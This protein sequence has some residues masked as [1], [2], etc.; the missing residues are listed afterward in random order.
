[1]LLNQGS[2]GGPRILCPASIATVTRHQVVN[3]ISWINPFIN[4]ASVE[5]ADTDVAGRAHH[6]EDSGARE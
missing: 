4:A 6:S 2:Y 3:A 1:M 5:Q